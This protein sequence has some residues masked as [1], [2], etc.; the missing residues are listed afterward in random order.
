[1]NAVQIFFI[2]IISIALMNHVIVIPFLLETAQRDAW[3]STLLTIVALV[4]WLPIV[5]F[6]MKQSKQTHL[7]VWFKT[8]F[9]RPLAYGISVLMSLYLLLISFV[10]MKDTITFTTTSYLTSTPNFVIL[11]ILS[12]LCFYNAYLGLS[13][14]AKTAGMI[15]PFVILL[16][17]FV[18]L[19]TTPFKDYS[20]LK[21][22][23]ENG[24]S[25]VFKSMI[26]A[27]AGY[28][29]A[30]LILWVQHQVDSKISFWKLTLFA[31]LAAS[32]TIGPTIGAIT[33][34]GPSEAASLRYPAFEQWRVISLGAYLEHFDFLSIFQWMAGAFIR[35]S[36]L[37][38]LIP[39][40][41]HITT[42]QS[43]LWILI[44]VYIVIGFAVMYPMS[45]DVFFEKLGTFILPIS[46]FFL[47]AMSLLIAFCALLARIKERRR[48]K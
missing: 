25:P 16:G 46:C 28:A 14:V 23:L 24:W 31:I 32:L 34:F 5:Y 2:L 7:F 10:T 17:I 20:L 9:G 11:I 3:I 33:E 4:L 42:R 8:T 13:S 19:A 43:R 47:I 26:Y 45:D 48:T 35:I 38:A 1:V 41:F 39:E 30:L 29:E 37:T 18:A 21:P 40:I 22:V 15:F 12:A 36:I 27:G 44:F 6:I